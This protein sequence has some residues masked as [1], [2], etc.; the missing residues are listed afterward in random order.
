MTNV[1]PGAV[2]PEMDKSES[3][4]DNTANAL[5]LLDRQSSSVMEADNGC[6]ND[7]ITQRRLHSLV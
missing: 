6:H 5:H 4:R 1:S 3:S 7:L 2:R